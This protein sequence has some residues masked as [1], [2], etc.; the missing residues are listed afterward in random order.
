[1]LR[2]APL[3]A[4][5]VSGEIRTV[6]A[7]SD[8]VSQ[9]SDSWPERFIRWR[10]ANEGIAGTGNVAIATASGMNLL[11]RFGGNFTTARRSDVSVVAFKLVPEIILS[12]DSEQRCWVVVSVTKTF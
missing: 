2:I 8:P 5:K 1:M 10:R 12:S 3:N 4:L 7:S 11:R 9:C 6:F